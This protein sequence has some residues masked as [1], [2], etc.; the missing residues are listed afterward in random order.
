MTFINYNIIILIHQYLGTLFRSLRHLF[1]A[2][3][4]PLFELYEIYNIWR[5]SMN[6]QTNIS[7]QSISIVGNLNKLFDDD[8]KRISIQDG[9]FDPMLYV[10]IN[11]AEGDEILFP[12]NAAEGVEVGI[13]INEFERVG[14]TDFIVNVPGAIIS[15]EQEIK[16]AINA[17]K[18]AG[19][20]YQIT[21][22]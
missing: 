13:V 7:S 11:S 8:L 5:I 17:Q 22:I 10:P 3:L 21:Y 19:K 15:K 4:W 9:N 12:L 20:L 6:Y 2:L 18:L 14:D 1:I 16:G